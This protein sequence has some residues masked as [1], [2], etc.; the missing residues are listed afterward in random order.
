[1]HPIS[2]A[3]LA[4]LRMHPISFSMKNFEYYMHTISFAMLTLLTTILSI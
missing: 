4:M 3:I 2:L 1:M